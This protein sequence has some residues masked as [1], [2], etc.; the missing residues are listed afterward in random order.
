MG[1]EYGVCE[2]ECLD[3]FVGFG[4]YVSKKRGGVAISILC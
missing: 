4:G 2:R 3:G 1:D